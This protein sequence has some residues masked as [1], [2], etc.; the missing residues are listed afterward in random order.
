MATKCQTTLIMQGL[1]M[2]QTCVVEIT[3]AVE[4]EPIMALNVRRKC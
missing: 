3:D 1:P 2:T 4:S